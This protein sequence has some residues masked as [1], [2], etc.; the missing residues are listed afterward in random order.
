M[1]TFKD[2]LKL[3]RKGLLEELVDAKKLSFK[4]KF[5]VRSEHSKDNSQISKA[6]KY[7]AKIM[8][9]LNTKQS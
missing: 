8:T 3:D 7:I 9:L 4:T 5:N 2:L 6:K 1:K